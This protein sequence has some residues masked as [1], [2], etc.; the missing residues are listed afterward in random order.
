[1]ID[2]SRYYRAYAEMKDTLEGD[3]A[4]MYLTSAMADADKG[5]DTLN[6]SMSN[7]V[8]DMDWVLKFEDCIPYIEKAIDEQRKFIEEYNEVDRIDKVKQVRKDAITHLTQHTN[9][10]QSI[11]P[12][13]SVI[14]EKLLN[15]H[16]EDSFATYENRFLYSLIF[17][18]ISFIEARF[19]ALQNAPND[20]FADSK[21]SR[22]LQLNKQKLNINFEYYFESH[23][24]QKIN[25]EEDLESLT[26]YERILRLRM[27][28]DDFVNTDLIQA[29]NG[30]LQVK[31][32]INKTNCIK[33]DP[34]F[35]KCYELWTFIETYLKPGYV[36]QVDEFDGTIHDEMKEELYDLMAYE[37]FVMLM[38]TNPALKDK[39]NAEY[40]ADK[41][42]REEEANKPE[43]EV[44][45]YIED[46]IYEV[47]RE[48]MALRLAEVR[49]RESQIMK[50]ESELEQAK[51]RVQELEKKVDELQSLV[52][53]REKELE[54]ARNEL[55]MVRVYVTKLEAC[56][57]SLTAKVNELNDYI[58]GLQDIINQQA[59]SVNSLNNQVDE[60]KLII[61]RFANEN[62][63][64]KE[65]I[66]EHENTIKSHENTIAQHA[67]VI[68][69][70]KAQYD[71][72]TSKHSDLQ[73]QYSNMV[74]EKDD[75]INTIKEE[76]EKLKYTIDNFDEYHKD[77]K[78]RAD[79]MLDKYNARESEVTAL[80]N[81]VQTQVLA[82]KKHDEEIANIRAEY[83]QRIAALQQQVV[84]ACN[85]SD[86][87][88][89]GIRLNAETKALEEDYNRKLE[90]ATKK[91]KAFV[92]RAK[93]LIKKDP[94]E[95]L[96]L[97]DSKLY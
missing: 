8:I 44:Q 71:E 49:D 91:A 23:E 60:Q 15:T 78:T 3:Y 82:M 92:K 46:K 13:G 24:R 74:S 73:D 89:Y 9:L 19:R 75:I 47:R 88:K 25:K 61:T 77:L 45:R 50:L 28:L 26:D 33:Q 6:G 20:S 41:K 90:A 42:R 68:K 31:S 37:H 36:L 72:L 38:N 70:S 21:I 43:E 80:T 39:L 51:E 94:Q 81:Q 16:R 97:E 48:E 4:K 83:E 57:A 11:E 93:V 55:R 12:D 58:I 22:E 66:S 96:N 76:K 87:Q 5:E 67:E 69:S 18:S 95:L 85:F 40:L 1:M 7:R 79:N 62:K 52:E 10:I 35:K 30:C 54:E 86:E 27:K 64:L 56:I 34:A 2:Y 32:P 63:S 59:A 53:V 17:K 84:A 65:T 14:P 29:L